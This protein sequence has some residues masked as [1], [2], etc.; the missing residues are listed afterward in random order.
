MKRANCIVGLV[1]LSLLSVAQVPARSVYAELSG[2]G[3]FLSLNYDAR[4]AKSDKG[5]GVRGGIGLVYD[6]YTFGFAIPVGLNY[7]AGEEN[8]FFEGGA[9]V[10]FFHK[11]EKNQ[12]SWIRFN[13]ESFLTPYLTAGYRY[14]PVAKK[15][16]FRAGLCLFLNN[17]GFPT[18]GG[19]PPLYPGFSFG[20]SIR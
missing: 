12:D 19:V 16:M 1:L 6:L 17:Q 7:L 20:Y 10:S 4:L 2:P 13:K 11:K 5:L 8:H 9:G 14:Q 18:L 15:F 3:G